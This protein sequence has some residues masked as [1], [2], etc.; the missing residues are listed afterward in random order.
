MYIV[1]SPLR[2]PRHESVFLVFLLLSFHLLT[3]S[4]INNN[5]NLITYKVW[6][7]GLGLELL[8]QTSTI[9]IHNY[10]VFKVCRG[11]YYI[12]L[13]LIITPSLVFMYLASLLLLMIHLF[14]LRF[15]YFGLPLPFLTF[16][17]PPIFQ[18]L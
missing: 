16:C 11:G 6:W 15:S 13:P 14:F 12:L 2:R 4:F 5:F 3:L 18:N 8:T 7:W 1:I 17:K 9:I 10:K